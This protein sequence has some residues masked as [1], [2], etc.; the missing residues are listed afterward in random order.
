M[1]KAIVASDHYDEIDDERTGLIVP[2][3]GSWE[4]RIRALLVDP[5]LRHLLGVNARDYAE[6]CLS[7]SVRGAEWR[8]AIT[9]IDRS[10]QAV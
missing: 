7:M 10:L 5:E 8:S 4:G 3:G 1:G 9:Q 2:A 6:R